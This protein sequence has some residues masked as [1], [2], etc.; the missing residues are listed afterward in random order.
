[1]A[2]LE[3]QAD[4]QILDRIGTKRLAFVL[5]WFGRDIAGGAEA[6]CYGLVSSLRQRYPGV[7]VEVITT[8]LQEFAGDWNQNVHPE[9]VRD[10]HG[11]SV[12]RF[13]AE[14]V[15]R[16]D[17][18]AMHRY[19]LVPATVADLRSR[20]GASVSPLNPSEEVE[21][22]KYMVHSEAM[23]TYLKKHKKAYDLFFFMPYMFATTV[24]GVAAVGNR[25][26]VIPCLHDERYAYMN[27]YR[28]MMSR[29]RGCLFH[30]EAER[31][32]AR[33]LYDMHRDYLLGEMVATR[34]DLGD[35]AA[36]RARFGITGPF[37]LYAGRK[38]AGKGVGNLVSMFR[39]IRRED[40]KFSDYKIV[41]IGKGDLDFGGLEAEGVYDLGF[42]SVQE[43]LDAMAAA[44]LFCMPSLFESF[45]IVIMEAWL[46]GTPVLV[47]QLC[48]VTRDHVLVGKGGLCYKSSEDFRQAVHSILG[49]QHLADEMAQNGRSYVL[50]NY[51]PTAVIDRFVEIVCDLN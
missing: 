20:Q 42:V 34:P 46:Q 45:S 30:V 4:Q 36:F 6:E 5:P 51:T 13:A 44:S 33:E 39:Q 10:E 43:K 3:V 11:I 7:Q 28:Q 16:S 26:V 27:L 25:A 22:L 17:F 19:R 38:V 24:R 40:P 50:D 23:F 48:Q 8:C 35:A 29:A 32:L 9:G 18:A 31:R 12:R 49:N 2:T 1:M 37:I 15:D 21:Y 14:A 41:I 47:N